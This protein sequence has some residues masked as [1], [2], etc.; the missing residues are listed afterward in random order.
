MGFR[1]RRYLLPFTAA[2]LEVS[3]R[4]SS[5]FVLALVVVALVLLTVSCGG[6][7]MMMMSSRQLQ[8]IAVS[9]TSAD[10]MN[11]PSGMVHFTAMGTYNMAPMTANPPVLWSLGNPFSAQ[12]I[13]AGV[14][15]DANGVAQCSGFMGIITIEATSPMDPNMPISKMSMSTMNV[16]GMAQLTCP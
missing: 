12:P 1:A 2:Y 10:A 14:S 8:S 3:M 5:A 7:S 15:I 9:P 16:V 6:N 13:P 4:R 11:F